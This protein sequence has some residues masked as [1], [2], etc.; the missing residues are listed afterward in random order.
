MDPCRIFEID[1]P[2]LWCMAV[3]KALATCDQN[4]LVACVHSPLSTIFAEK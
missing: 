1:N 2:S 3:P 4:N